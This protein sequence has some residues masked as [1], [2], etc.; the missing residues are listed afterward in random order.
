MTDSCCHISDEAI[1]DQAREELDK[2]TSTLKAMR[3]KAIVWVA[4]FRKEGVIEVPWDFA[5]NSVEAV[6]VDD[7]TGM[8]VPKG[9]LV[10][11]RPDEGIYHQVDGVRLCFIE[12]QH[13]MLVQ[14]AA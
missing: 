12:G 11:I 14:E 6:M 10:M 2:I 13:L 7:G 3:G 1:F 4:P 9:T 5:P 8:E